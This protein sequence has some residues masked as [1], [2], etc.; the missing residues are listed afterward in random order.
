MAKQ[1]NIRELTKYMMATRSAV[2]RGHSA[3]MIEL[4]LDAEKRAKVNAKTQFIGRGERTLTGRLLNSIFSG[5]TLTQGRSLPSGFIGTRGIPYGRVHEYGDTIRPV[6]AKHLWVKNFRGK[7]KKFKRMTP[8]EWF[9]QFKSSVGSS[10]SAGSGKN[11]KQKFQFGF[12]R[13]GEPY[14][15]GVNNKGEFTPLFFLKDEVKIPARPY[16]TPAVR[17]AMANYPRAANK[18]LRSALSKIFFS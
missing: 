13:A 9:T 7:A 8:K 15:A 4:T 5:F 12:N 3:A 10:G 18:H 17:D 14:A 2:I 11:A 6:K 1:R 16:L